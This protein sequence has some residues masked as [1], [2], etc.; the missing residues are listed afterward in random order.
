M[1]R[2]TLA[3]TLAL[4]LPA[5]LL[6]GCGSADD[7]DTATGDDT[8][9]ADTAAAADDPYAYLA[10]FDYSAL[11]DENGYAS[12]VTALDYVTLP[13]NYAAPELPAGT[14]TVTDEEVEAFISDSVLSYFAEE[15]HV[16]DRAAEMGD[17][18]N[19]DYVG[20][21][22]GV[23]FAG[24]STNGNGSTLQLTGYNF[25]DDFEQQI[26]GHTPGESFDVIVTFPDPYENN[27][28]LAGKEAKFA[29]TLNYIVEQQLPELT[30]DFVAENMTADT[31]CKT[32]DELRAYFKDRML[33][34]QQ[35]N[36]VYALLDESVTYADGVP[37]TMQDFF[38]DWALYSPWQ[39]AAMY[40]TN[41]DDFLTQTG[42]ESVDDY[43]ED[44]QEGI[45]ANAH[46]VLLAQAMAEDMGLVCDDAAFEENFA[47]TFGSPDPTAYREQYGEGYL[48]MSVLEHMVMKKILENAT[49]A[50]E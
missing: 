3:L 46:Q 16:T 48:K 11:F 5:A 17:T 32:A 24:G 38:T 22:D 10:D 37:G 39:Y 4:L 30:D 18:V 19:I 50:K 2:K 7:A 25:I 1:R 35:S 41:L 20:T 6:A 47:D 13:E 31:G 9:S 23:E 43:L 8:G 15:L 33:F 14:D 42:Y 28:D 44:S 26:A 34:N 45:T 29:T 21:L 27:P 12:G 40:G 36:A 49:F